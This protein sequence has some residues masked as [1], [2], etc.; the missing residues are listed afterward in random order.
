MEYAHT[1]IMKNIHL[2]LLAG[3]IPLFLACNPQQKTDTPIEQPKHLL[4]DYE[5]FTVDSLVNVVIEIPAGTNEKWEINKTTGQL[6]WQQITADSSRVVDYLS[7]P[8]NY[9]FVPQTLLSKETGGDGD[10]VDVFV[11][12]ASLNRSSIVPV[13]IIGMIHMLDNQESDSKLIAVPANASVLKVESFT[14][15]QADYPGIIEILQLWL[16]HYKGTN[17]VE[18]QSVLGEVEALA[19]LKKAYLDYLK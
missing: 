1:H 13:K 15:L 10:P 12:G 11:L 3:L 5:A 2:L 16:L 19:Y 7:Y 8:G 6:E 14:Q 17:Q 18:M 9:G 4:H